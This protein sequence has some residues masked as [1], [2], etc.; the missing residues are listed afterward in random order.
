MATEKIKSNWKDYSNVYNALFIIINLITKI[1]GIGYIIYIIIDLDRI[2]SWLIA[3]TLNVLID[4]LIYKII[5]RRW[6][7]NKKP[8]IVFNIINIILVTYGIDILISTLL[9]LSEY[10]IILIVLCILIA[11][12]I[13]YLH[14]KI[15]II[16]FKEKAKLIKDDEELEKIHKDAEEVAKAVAEKGEK[17]KEMFAQNNSEGGE[18]K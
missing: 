6:K 15:L 9:R 10:E 12:I 5:K 11:T 13:E 7:A 4:Y 18:S 17:L 1:V 14:Y 3:V 16:I 2:P 8:I